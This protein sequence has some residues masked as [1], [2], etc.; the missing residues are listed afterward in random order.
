SYYKTP[1][2]YKLHPNALPS[3]RLLIQMIKQSQNS[4]ISFLCLFISLFYCLTWCHERVTKLALKSLLRRS[5]VHF[6][7]QIRTRHLCAIRSGSRTEHSLR[8]SGRRALG[9]R[10]VS[11]GIR[12]STL[13]DPAALAQMRTSCK[14]EIWLTRSSGVC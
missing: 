1:V 9:R 2:V 5:L 3:A 12:C 11:R 10:P 8:T 13:I 4:L 7:Q 6:S 14:T